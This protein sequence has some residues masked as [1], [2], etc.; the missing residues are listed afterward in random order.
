VTRDVAPG[1]T[2]FVAAGVAHRFHDITE[3]LRLIVVFGPA[4]HSRAP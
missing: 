4:E 2:I 3:A 1:D